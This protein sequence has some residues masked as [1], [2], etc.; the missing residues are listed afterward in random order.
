MLII[1]DFIKM[2]ACGMWQ[3]GLSCIFQYSSQKHIA[4]ASKRLIYCTT[5]MLTIKNE[6]GMRGFL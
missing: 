4:D 5:I 2:R 1:G 3:F 6:G